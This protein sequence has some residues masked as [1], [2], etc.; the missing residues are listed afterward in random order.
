MLPCTLR[1]RAAGSAALCVLLAAFCTSCAG[2][3]PAA[4]RP[5]DPAAP[6]LILVAG[7]VYRQ[8]SD[9]P[10]ATA[11]E[12]PAHA[13]RVSDFRIGRHEVTV[14]QFRRF[15]ETAGYRTDVERA[16]GALDIDPA[17]GTLVRRPGISWRTP[18]YPVADDLPVTWVSWNDAKAYT[19]WLAGVTG[20]AFRLPTEAEWEFAARDRG[21]SERWSGTSDRALLGEV[22]WHDRT[23]SGRP[24]PVGK[25]RPN[26]LGLYDLSGNVWE[27]CEDG[28][29]R[30][31]ETAA[32]L[33]DPAGDPS[34]PYRALRGGSWRV[35]AATVT[36]TYRNGY[37]ADYAHSSI[38]FRV[39]LSAAERGR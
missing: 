16:G 26:A 38:G 3:L 30:Y 5:D 2:G 36:T 27:W 25:L 15:V 37:R 11:E 17:M 13:V 1:H 8:G 34:S 35:D 31:P 18:G 10:Q 21:R 12:R 23:S 4:A 39:A 14:G 19:S 9:A 7:G 29:R 28:F 33:E 32:P 24:H 6:D 22:A 20:R